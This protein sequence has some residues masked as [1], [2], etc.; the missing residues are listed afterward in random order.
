MLW[1][2]VSA[3]I[4]DNNSLIKAKFSRKD[5]C[6]NYDLEAAIIKA[7]SHDNYLINTRNAQIVFL[8]IRASPISLRPFV[9]AL[10]KRMEKTRS[11]VVALKGLMLMH[12]VLRFK[13]KERRSH[14][15]NTIKSPASTSI[16]VAESF[17]RPK[18]A[19]FAWLL[20]KVR[21]LADNMNVGLIIEAMNCVTV[22]IFDVYRKICNEIAKVLLKIH[23]IN[24]LEAELVLEI[25]QKATE[26][27]EEI[28]LFLDFRS[29][30]YGT[31][32]NAMN[33]RRSRRFSRKM[34]D[35]NLRGSPMAILTRLAETLVSWKTINGKR[36]D[37]RK[38]Y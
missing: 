1:K 6:R 20:L 26:H 21:P 38:L 17:E 23:S 30:Y 29:E 25:L 16:E 35:K 12:G 33:F 2:L 32:I 4:K 27:A 28:S 5:S 22:E 18:F 19:I 37:K 9:W 34:F 31:P 3:A 14:M 8:W 11:W 13:I 24:K 36:F 15:I 7:T 10:S